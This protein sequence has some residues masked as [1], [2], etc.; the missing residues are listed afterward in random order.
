MKT[1]KGRKDGTGIMN[2]DKTIITGD[3]INIEQ[4]I[5]ALKTSRPTF[6]RW[7]RK[8]VIR[9]TK[10]G[11]Q[12]RFRKEDIDRLIK[13][14]K[15]ILTL[16]VNI[17]PLLATLEQFA[18]DR[19]I[20]M[21]KLRDPNEVL[22]A[23]SMILF[24]AVK[25]KASDIHFLPAITRD[26]NKTGQIKFRMMGTMQ[27]VA[28][29]DI[30]L[31]PP[32]IERL[33][34]MAN[35]NIQETMLP[36]DG[37]IQINVTGDDIDMRVSFLPTCLGESA[38]LRIMSRQNEILTLDKMDIPDYVRG[39]IKKALDGLHGMIVVSGPNS[40]GKSTTLYAC[41][42][43]L[44][45]KNKKIITIEDPV[46]FL[47][48]GVEHVS[49]NTDKGMTHAKMLGVARRSA[50]DC[51]MIDQLKDHETFAM[52]QQTALNNIILSSVYASDAADVL[53]RFLKFGSNAD[54][55]GDAV[56]LVTAQRLVRK[57]CLNCAIKINPTHDV[58][59]RPKSIIEAAGLNWHELQQSYKKPVGCTE[60]N[61]TGFYG[62]TVLMEV[63][64]ITPEIVT[65]L[66]ENPDPEKI[67]EIA[68]KQGMKSM[69]VQG[70]CKAAN[71][72]V[73]L[74]EVFAMLAL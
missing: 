68:T 42:S 64:E 67:R 38:T 49:V 17:Q 7:L 52:A 4:A 71:G 29:F 24:M 21:P 59:T 46:L 25:M 70:I 1:K 19:K 31:L 62:R 53:M 63:M 13:G 15:P 28:S 72:E 44:I 35:C 55:I 39:A 14:E 8:G 69:A 9:G 60:C 27:D 61:G 47:L 18:V 16:P 50:P 36:Q 23:V 37:R 51:I 3:L 10:I 41:L 5:N 43:Y 58:L 6:Y 40:S 2:E 32:L 57:L 26:G 54:I 34:I 65:V 73:T 30:R 45:P 56:K 74:S 20:N 66:R 11:R 12:W 22:Q 33:K 48:P